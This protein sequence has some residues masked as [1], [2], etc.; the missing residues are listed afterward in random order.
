MGSPLSTLALRETDTPPFPSKP[1]PTYFGPVV[2]NTVFALFVLSQTTCEPQRDIPQGKSLPVALQKESPLP[3]GTMV[4]PMQSPS[5][6]PVGL[7]HTSEN[8]ILCLGKQQF[9]MVSCTIGSRI[10]PLDAEILPGIKVRDVLW[11]INTTEES[12]LL[13]HSQ[14]GTFSLSQSAIDYVGQTVSD[15]PHAESATDPIVVKG[16]EYVMNLDPAGEALYYPA[17]AM[18]QEVPPL[19]G[20]FSIT[21]LPLCEPKRRLAKLK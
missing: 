2:R 9:R 1:S 14:F 7:L 19:E 8:L 17:K 10:I 6:E 11:N 21:V 15:A 13:F 4:L 20:N 18:G 5:G 16:I 12:G 3:D